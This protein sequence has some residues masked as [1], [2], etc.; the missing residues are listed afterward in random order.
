MNVHYWKVDLPRPVEEVLYA[1]EL[2]LVSKTF[3]NL[4]GRLK[5]GK[6]HWTQML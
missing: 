2:A 1:D 3:E 5:L 4:K 6:E